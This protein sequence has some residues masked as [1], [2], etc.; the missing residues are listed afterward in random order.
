MVKWNTRGFIYS[1]SISNGCRNG[2]IEHGGLS[3]TTIYSTANGWGGSSNLVFG[4][5]GLTGAESNYYIPNTLAWDDVEAFSA[6]ENYQ[7]GDI[8]LSG[9]QFLQANVI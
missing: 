1:R 8:V 2:A 7:S 4:Q 5:Q 6:T 3:D 9:G